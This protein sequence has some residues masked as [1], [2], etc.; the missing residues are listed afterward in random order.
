VHQNPERRRV[1]R[2]RLRV[3]AT[4]NLFFAGSSPPRRQD[5][6]EGRAS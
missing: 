1:E 3:L 6:S 2:L 5:A 4:L